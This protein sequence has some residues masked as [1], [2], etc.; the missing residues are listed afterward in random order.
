MSYED[1]RRGS[2][3]GGVAVIIAVVLAAGLLLVAVLVAGGLFFFALQRPGVTASRPAPVAAVLAGTQLDA[4]TF[5]AAAL[6][7]VEKRIGVKLPAGSRGLHLLRR[8]GGPPAAD[9]AFI[10]KIDIPAKSAAAFATRLSALPGPV[11]GGTTGIDWPGIGQVGWWQPVKA[12]VLAERLFDP[13]GRGD[14]L[15]LLLCREG[16]KRALYVMWV[17]L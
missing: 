13:T 8:E 12:N 5:G 17:Q 7:K 6:R 4:T 10:A 9:P 3:A 1:E 14:G 11:G 16:E 2:G 15:H